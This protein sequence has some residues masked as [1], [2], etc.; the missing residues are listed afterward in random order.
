VAGDNS[1]WG[2]N[3]GEALFDRCDA[4]SFFATKLKEM[5][6]LSD[7]RAIEMPDRSCIRAFLRLAVVRYLLGVTA[8]RGQKVKVEVASS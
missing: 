3:K 2:R 5:H 1:W 8:A 4:P 7:L 6:F